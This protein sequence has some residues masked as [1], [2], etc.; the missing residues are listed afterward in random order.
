MAQAQE[1]NDEELVQVAGGSA[2]TPALA[3]LESW[4]TMSDPGPTCT[5][6]FFFPSSTIPT[7]GSA[8]FQDISTTAL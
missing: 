1:I 7:L 5:S 2:N 3:D 4:I 6:G 8:G